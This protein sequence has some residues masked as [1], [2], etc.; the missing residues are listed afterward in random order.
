VNKFAGQVPPTGAN[1]IQKIINFGEVGFKN[2][3]NVVIK[4]ITITYGPEE[5]SNPITVGFVGGPGI[6]KYVQEPVLEGGLG[7]GVNIHFNTPAGTHFVAFS[8]GGVLGGFGNF[9]ECKSFLNIPLL[10]FIRVLISFWSRFAGLDDLTDENHM[11]DLRK[12]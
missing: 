12:V 1:Q 7:T 11:T 9:T 4:N 10:F 2:A 5:A 8:F 3:Q 6:T